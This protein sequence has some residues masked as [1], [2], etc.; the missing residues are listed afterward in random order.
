MQKHY[1]V[2][3]DTSAESFL[4]I[5]FA[6]LPDRSVLMSQPKLLNKVLKEYPK[7]NGYKS[8]KHP[9]GPQPSAGHEDQYAKVPPIEQGKYLRLL[10]ILLYLTKSRP[11]IMTA[12]SFGATKS[13]APNAMDYRNLLYIVEYLRI[14]PTKGHRIY[15]NKDQPIQLYCTVG[16][17]PS[18]GELHPAPLCCQKKTLKEVN[19]L[20]ELVTMA[21]LPTIYK[22]HCSRY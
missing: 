7:L 13:H 22:Q 16:A 5:H 9:Y 4:A 14:T 11:D 6:H 2:F 20:Q 15:S 8:K 1:Q 19:F 12:V 18:S 10:G 17:F 21:L 3:L